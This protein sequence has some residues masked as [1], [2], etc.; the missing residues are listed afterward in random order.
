MG[1][2]LPKVLQELQATM[3]RKREAIGINNKALFNPCQS[4]GIRS[5]LP[6]TRPPITTSVRKK[7]WL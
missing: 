6:G 3:R 7:H 5:I 4:S 1:M 2:L